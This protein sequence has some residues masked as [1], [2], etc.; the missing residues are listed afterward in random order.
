MKKSPPSPAGPGIITN[1]PTPPEAGIEQMNEHDNQHPQPPTTPTMQ[2]GQ[3]GQTV[4]H[5]QN[6]QTG[7]TRTALADAVATLRAHYVDFEAIAMKQASVAMRSGGHGSVTVAPVPVNVG[8]WSLKCDIDRLCLEAMRALR[9]PAGG[10]DAVDMLKA[11]GRP[12][13]LDRLLQRDDAERLVGLMVQAAG[14][15]M[16]WLERSPERT[17]IGQCP[18]CGGDLWAE[19]DDLDGGWMVCRCGSTLRVR[20]VVQARVWRLSLC[21][22]QGTAAGLADLLKACGI[23]VR[24]KTISEWRRRGIIDAVG[25]EDG[26]PVFRLWDVWRALNRHAVDES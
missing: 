22:A 14:R 25:L 3:T 15:M 6:R 4:Q 21:G 26:K 8:A 13:C 12:S 16:R 11:V 17:M 7:Q 19:R 23:R 9:L 24:R 5:E 18:Q 1:Q 20:D 2:T 10:R